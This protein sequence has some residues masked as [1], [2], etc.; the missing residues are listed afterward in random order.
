MSVDALGGR[1]R[2]IAEASD[3][4]MMQSAFD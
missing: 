3:M 2:K 4:G 1:A